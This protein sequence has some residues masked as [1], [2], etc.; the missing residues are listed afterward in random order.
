MD[1]I[2][3]IVVIQILSF[4]LFEIIEKSL[5][6]ASV[7]DSAVFAE[8]T[9]VSQVHIDQKSNILEGCCKMCGVCCADSS[10]VYDVVLPKGIRYQVK[11][12]SGSCARCWCNPNHELMLGLK[13]FDGKKHGDKDILNI[14]KPFKCCCPAICSCCMKEIAITHNDRPVGF[15]QQPQCGG[16]FT[17]RLNMY[18]KA[19]G[20]QI[21]IVTGPGC[22]MGGCCASEFAVNDMQNKPLATIKRLGIGDNGVRRALTTDADRYQVDFTNQDEALNTKLTVLSTTLMLDYMF[23]E[24]ETNCSFNCCVC[25]PYIACK[26]CDMYCC[27]ATLPCKIRCFVPVEEAAKAAVL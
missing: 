27:G 19:N 5:N 26:L 11:E 1:S 17:P 21:G 22:C 9:G 4:F 15:V 25:P 7:I 20:A 13:T 24:G 23:F 12:H 14:L 2:L 6:M 8:L 3:F 10:N 16:C 18:D